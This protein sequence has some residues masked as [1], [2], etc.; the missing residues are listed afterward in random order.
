MQSTFDLKFEPEAKPL[1]K[2]TIV[3]LVVYTL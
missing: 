1:K 3:I 2:F